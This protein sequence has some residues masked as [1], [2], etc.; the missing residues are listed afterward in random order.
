MGQVVSYLERDWIG[1]VVFQPQNLG[2]L[3]RERACKGRIVS[4]DVECK[5]CPNT[6]A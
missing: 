5:R 6:N 4:G 1:V 3:L 2:D